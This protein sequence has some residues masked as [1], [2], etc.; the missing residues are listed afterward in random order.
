MIANI[1]D[2]KRSFE[3]EEIKYQT[4][5]QILLGLEKAVHLCENPWLSDGNLEESKL[6]VPKAREYLKFVNVSFGNSCR[7]EKQ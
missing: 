1:L 6:I 2:N 3:E 4:L 7:N 5:Q